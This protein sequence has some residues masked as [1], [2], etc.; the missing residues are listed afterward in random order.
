MS[1]P[2]VRPRAISPDPP[3]KRCPWCDDHAV[4]IRWGHSTLTEG[5]TYHVHCYICRACGPSSYNVDFAIARWNGMY[6]QR[7]DMLS[8]I[9]QAESVLRETKLKLRFTDDDDDEF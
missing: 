9:L 5:V 4:G 8:G 6:G 7:M 3:P 2:Y 1:E